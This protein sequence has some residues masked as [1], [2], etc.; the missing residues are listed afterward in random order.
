MAGITTAADE[1]VFHIE[2]WLGLNENPGGDTKLKQG[3]AAAMRNFRVT[4][5]GNLQRRPGTAMVK[6]L[7]QSYSLDID[8]E[9]AVV[10]EDDTIPGQLTMYPEAAATADGF[11]S[12]TGEAVV[13][14]SDNAADYAGYYWQYNVNFTYQLVSCARDE[15]TD[16]Y[17]WT[18]K[19]VRAVSSSTDQNVA[20]LWA[21]NVKGTEYLVGACDGK[22]WKLHD[23]TDFCKAEIGDLSTAA[24]VFFFGYSEKLYILGGGQYKEWD[25][26]DLK[27]VEGY[28]PL[29]SVAVVPG[30][31][32]M[33]LEQVNK[34]TGA[35]RCWFSPDG[36]A[37]TFV[38]PE[39][40]LASLDY[41]KDI[42]KQE[43]L[44][45]DDYTADQETGTVTFKTA[46]G[47]GVNSIEIGWTVKTNFRSQV[48]AMKFSENF[49][50]ATDNRVFLY[51]DG[52][53]QA[54]YSG[55]DHDGNPRAD[56]FP[57]MNVL[58]IGDANTPITALIRHYSRLIVYKADSAYSVQYGVT[59]LV[60]NSTM[61]TFYATPINRAIGNAAPGQVR[62]VLN[63]PRSLYGHDLYEWKNNSSYSGNMSVDERQARRISDRITATLNSFDLRAC[64]C[65]DDNDSQEYYICCG[66]KALVHNYAVDAWYFYDN[67]PACCLVNFRGE[68]YMGD[69]SGQLRSIAYRHRTDNGAVIRSYWESGSVAFDRDYMRKYSSMLWIG[70]KPEEHGEVHVTV[71]T[72]R[73]STYATKVVSSSLVT[74]ERADFRRWS[75]NTNRKPHIKRLK[76][77]AKKFV[78]YKLILQTEAINTTV[79]VLSA[80]M[81]VR[82]TGYAR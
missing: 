49:N 65:W 21:G 66:D 40:D 3:E 46:P 4:R 25:G 58:K 32:G 81:R 56:Y 23:G 34:L 17:F 80:S 15:G 82:F 12:L 14:S 52:S 69:R 67:F 63:S 18:M 1:R 76:I 41:V 13:V 2:A 42:I 19:R 72:D 37:V 53:N 9:G 70:I 51:G 57:D 73:K 29:V 64:V 50:G 74:F 62:L 79:T 61:A 60:D 35:R 5:D 11:V 27:D 20:G 77:K 55:L 78:F 28:R 75:F 8:E 30:G 44:A 24:P 39:K 54:F 59:T 26:T 6:G 22:L 33:G 48:L 16:R 7:M 71:Q 47:R 43:N 36:E 45:A 68:L 31:G 38:L 10:R